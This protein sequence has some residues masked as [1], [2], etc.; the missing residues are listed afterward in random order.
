MYVVVLLAGV[1]HTINSDGFF[2]LETQP[3]R[4]AFIGGGYISVELAGVMNTLGTKVTLLARSG[5]LRT[6]D[7]RV[8]VGVLCALPPRRV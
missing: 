3:K 5:I 8:R 2:E 4:M 6:F 7:V 1:E